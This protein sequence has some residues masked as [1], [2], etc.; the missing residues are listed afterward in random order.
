[1]ARLCLKRAERLSRV[2][3]LPALKRVRGKKGILSRSDHY[4]SVLHAPCHVPC[5]NVHAGRLAS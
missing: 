2:A 4:Q 1:M 5:Q 3:P